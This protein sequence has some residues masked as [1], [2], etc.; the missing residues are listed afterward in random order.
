MFNKLGKKISSLFKGSDDH[1]DQ[2]NVKK[3]GQRE[4]L[5]R[6]RSGIFTLD[7]FEQQMGMIDK[8]GSISKVMRFM[9]GAQGMKISPQMVEQMKIEMKRFSTIIKVMTEN[10][11]ANPQSLSNTRKQEIASK[12]GV[13]VIDI[14]NLINR[15]EKS[16]QLM[17]Q[18]KE[19][20][21]L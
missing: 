10:E 15:F 3:M 7:D 2:S 12:T 17:K 8:I 20:G 5:E 11:K 13:Q 21:R 6:I 18:Y 19:S 1:K 16:K 4:S 14:T 9:P